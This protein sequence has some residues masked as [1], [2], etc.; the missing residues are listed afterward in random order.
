MHTCAYCGCDI[1]RKPSNGQAPKYCNQ[2]HSHL[3]RI[4][5]P[6]VMKKKK[7]TECEYCHAM[8]TPTRSNR[9]QKFCCPD[10]KRRA[11]NEKQLVHDK[12]RRISSPMKTKKSRQ[13]IDERIE[14][15]GRA[16]QLPGYNPHH[17]EQFVIYDIMN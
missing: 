1:D 14:A 17:P 16:A 6:L 12:A 10:H 15:I 3:D 8:F 7:Q 4:G 13:S 5:K 9:A 2:E 11:K